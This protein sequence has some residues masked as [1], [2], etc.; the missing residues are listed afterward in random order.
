MPRCISER[1]PQPTLDFRLDDLDHFICEKTGVPP[2]AIWA[3]LS[4]GRPLKGDNVR[5]L[6]GLEDQ[7][8][9]LSWLNPSVPSC[10]RRRSMSSTR[11]TSML[12]S[13]KSYIPSI[14]S[15]SSSLP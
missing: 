2:E 6:A 3:Y 15:P 5:E 11:P 7:V 13:S 12:N 14:A 1:L 10:Y 4:D 8:S 9:V